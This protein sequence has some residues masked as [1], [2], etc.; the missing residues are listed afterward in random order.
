MNRSE[1]VWPCTHTELDNVEPTS[2]TEPLGVHATEALRLLLSLETSQLAPVIADVLQ[3]RWALWEMLVASVQKGSV[4]KVTYATSDTRL[5][6]L[7]SKFKT[8]FFFAP[9]H[10]NPIFSCFKLNVNENK[11]G[12]ESRGICTRGAKRPRVGCF[13]RFVSVFVSIYV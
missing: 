7:K 2:G 1:T 10:G 8:D 5:N 13:P 9:L 12:N 6:L 4:F 3:V 11:N